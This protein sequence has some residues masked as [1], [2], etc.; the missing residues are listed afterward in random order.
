MLEYLHHYLHNDGFYPFLLA[1]NM[2]RG[3]NYATDPIRERYE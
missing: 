3:Y 1:N 2:M